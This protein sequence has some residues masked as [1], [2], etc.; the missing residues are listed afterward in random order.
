MKNKLNHST[1]EFINLIFATSEVTALNVVVCLLSPS[2]TGSVQ[3]EGP[4][5]VGGI[6]EVLA[7]GEDFMNEIFNTDDSS[8]AKNLLNEFVRD[9]G[10]T[11]EIVLGKTALVDQLTDTLQIW[12]TPGDVGLANTQHVDSGLIQLDKDAVVDL[13]QSEELKGFAYLRVD[14]VDTTNTH[15]KGQLGLC[16]NVVIALVSCLTGHPDLI[17]LLIP[18][19]LHILFC[20]LENLDTLVSLKTT[21]RG[22]TLKKKSL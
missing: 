5:E 22:S 12:V 16:L 3:L 21:L 7:N 18:V 1:Q 20:P 4:E 15:D 19:F 11:T 13:S 2:A 10:F 8:A 17:T 14:L 6:L 9:D